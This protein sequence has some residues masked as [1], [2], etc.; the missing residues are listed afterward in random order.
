MEDK[1]KDLGISGDRK[2]EADDA[3]EINEGGCNCCSGSECHIEGP[4][5]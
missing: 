1:T 2:K 5:D 3:A 4:D